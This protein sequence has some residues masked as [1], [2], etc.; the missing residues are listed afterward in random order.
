[1]RDGLRVVAAV[2]ALL[3]S[4][5]FS[6]VGEPDYW[7]YQRARHDGGVPVLDGSADGGGGV[8]VGPQ[9]CPKV[10]CAAYGAVESIEALSAQIATLTWAAVARPTSA[11]LP[12]S[13]D[14]AVNRTVHLTSADIPLPPQCLAPGACAGV[15]FLLSEKAQGVGCL[16]DFCTTL[17]LTNAQFRLRLIV[18]DQYPDIPRYV[19]IAEV[20][21]SCRVPCE[22][23]ELRCMAHD[24]CWADPRDFCR[25]CVAAPQ[26]ECACLDKLEGDS[27]LYYVTNDLTCSGSCRDDRCVLNAGQ[28]NCPAL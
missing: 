4:G 10:A 14:L 8:V 9:G 13:S 6:P 22:A 20:L 27:C 23:G 28:P 19:P 21:P 25:F 2:G 16:D 26:A 24:T 7:A 5:C 3:G 11:C 17:M 18:H 1:M 12:A 15:T